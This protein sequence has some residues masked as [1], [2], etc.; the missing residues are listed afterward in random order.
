MALNKK[1]DGR[2]FDAFLKREAMPE[3]ATATA[4]QR[5]IA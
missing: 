4:V 1:H 5:V 2:D 3:A